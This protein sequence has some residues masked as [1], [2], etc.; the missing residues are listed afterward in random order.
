MIDLPRQDKQKIVF[1]L[2]HFQKFPREW[3]I[4]IKVCSGIVQDLFSRYIWAQIDWTY[5]SA[6][7][8]IDRAIFQFLTDFD[9]HTPFDFIISWLNQGL[10][11]RYVGITIIVVY[12]FT[13]FSRINIGHTFIN[14]ENGWRRKKSKN[15]HK[16]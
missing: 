14:L 5:L 3:C 13:P 7:N 1:F 2:F 12:L 4:G 9:D 11:Q 10:W 16:A 8:R 15:D 6:L